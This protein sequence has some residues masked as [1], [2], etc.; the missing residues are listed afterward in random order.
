M[1]QSVSAE[2]I[3]VYVLGGFRLRVGEQELTE[4]DYR[5]PRLWAVLA[6]L[7]LNR[8]R[9]IPQTELIEHFWPDEQGQ[10][11]IG[12]LKTTVY[13]LRRMLL[14]ML[15]EEERLPLHS[16]RGSYQWDPEV[17]CQVDVERFTWLCETAGREIE[18]DRRRI[19]CYQE[20]IE[21][22]QGGFLPR[23]AGLTWQAASFA[24][25]HILYSEAIN[26]CAALLEQA[27]D[28]PRMQKI[29]EEA[30]ERDPLDEELYVLL[31][32]AL[33]HQKKY[34]AAQ[35]QYEK[36]AEILYRE[37]GVFPSE[38]LR[39][40]HHEIMDEK[41]EPS[42]DLDSILE[43]LREGYSGGAYVCPYG[44]FKE[45]YHLEAR[46]SA[47]SGT[48]AHVA[49][50]T[51]EEERREEA[52]RLRAILQKSLRQGDVIAQYSLRQFIVLL[53]TANY[54]ESIMICQRVCSAFYR[55]RRGGSLK[56]SIRA[57]ELYNRGETI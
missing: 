39:S 28:Y 42:T 14:G 19:A 41:K 31:I 6:Y 11:P 32:R 18:E 9:Q 46:R 56:F 38:A 21:L 5:S 34:T 52:E 37:L 57:M 53:P 40:L 2:P 8:H 22:Y 29:C 51:L 7:I 26:R 25:C 24:R 43:Q 45:I 49:M 12:A 17:P 16:A 35:Q 15:G 48:C 20:A 27:G 1:T 47:R 23:A 44:V 3:R 10:N 4:K 50:L 33:L 54:E 13:R 55:R 36:A 30:I